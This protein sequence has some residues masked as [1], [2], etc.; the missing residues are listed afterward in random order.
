MKYRRHLII[1][2]LIGLFLNMKVAPVCAQSP[3]Q[4]S[5]VKAVLFFSPSCGHCYKV[6]SE[7]LPPI[8]EK[9]GEQLYL[10][11]V[12]VTG[13]AGGAMFDIVLQHYNL[14]SAGVPFLLVGDTYLVGSV[15]IP[16]KFPG[17]ID[18]YLAQGGVDWPPI[19][20]LAEVL[21][22]DEPSET[23]A[24]VESTPTST[25]NNPVGSP[26]TVFATSTASPPSASLSE[27]ITP[28]SPALQPKPSPT[29]GLL[30]TGEHQDSLPE[31][32]RRDLRGNSLAVIVLV[33][34]VLSAVAGI[35]PWQ[36]IPG[37]GY[38][39]RVDWLIPLLS[40]VGLL[41]AGYLAYVETTQVEAVCGPV[42]DCNT[43]QQ[44]DYARL[45]GVLPIGVLGIG[46]Y[47]LILFAWVISRSAALRPAA[48][49][50]LALLG[51]TSFGLLF[52]IYLTFLEPFVI[53]ATCI[54][55][56]TSAVIM[57]A[58]FWLS[59]KPARQALQD[60]KSKKI[61]KYR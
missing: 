57:T 46:G 13:P 50:R 38:R 54:W 18:Q 29:P 47:I 25:S 1:V 59:L 31:K 10:I 32:F 5:V 2:F 41:V 16:E 53:G 39:S 51:L 55:C 8:F 28:T 48:Y 35:I 7:V 9:Y 11:G 33:A 6:I 43:V 14:E 26:T 37:T 22:S 4:D 24:P 40:L 27:P 23:A 36:R 30:M 58:L 21:A 3:T 34:M 56:L 12:D 17:L 19:P 45:F 42:G 20:G 49:A 52:S 44:S 61:N 60:L 15:D